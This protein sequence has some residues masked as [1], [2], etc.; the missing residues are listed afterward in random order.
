MRN[1]WP[2]MRVVITVALVAATAL[3]LG[4]VFFRGSTT[5]Q[6]SRQELLDLFGRLKTGT[7]LSTLSD[8]LAKDGYRNL[9]LLK[10]SS[11]LLVVRTPYEFGAGNWVLFV[12][13]TN[14]VVSGLRIRVEDS[15]RMK[16]I[17]SPPDR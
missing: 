10:V 8:M 15:D 14:E 3:L 17:E 9:R 2:R 12:D 6:A 13:T 7:S 11:N 5:G 16:P 1:A 4:L